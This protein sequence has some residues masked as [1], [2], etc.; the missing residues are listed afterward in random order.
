MSCEFGYKGDCCCECEHLI[1]ID[2]C[3]CK[4]C[5]KVEGWICKIF[6]EMS[7][8]QGEQGVMK[9]MTREHGCC[10]MWTKRKDYKKE[11][12]IG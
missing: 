9:H 11:P 12:T 5:S 6:Y 1:P 4:H 3:S 10:E 2:V 8:A 7:Q